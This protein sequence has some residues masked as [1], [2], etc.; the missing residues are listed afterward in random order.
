MRRQHALCGICTPQ[1]CEEHSPHHSLTPYRLNIRL[2]STNLVFKIRLCSS[3]ATHIQTACFG[4]APMHAA[5]A[6]IR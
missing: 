5:S 2:C 1:L 4:C 6:C 3:L